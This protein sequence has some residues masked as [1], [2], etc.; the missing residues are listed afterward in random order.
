L[1]DKLKKYDE[2]INEEEYQTKKKWVTWPYS[3]K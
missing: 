2:K 1:D 3:M